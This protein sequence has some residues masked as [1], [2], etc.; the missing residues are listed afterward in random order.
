MNSSTKSKN[1]KPT[2]NKQRKVLAA[3][4]RTGQVDV[5]DL[6]ESGSRIQKLDVLVDRMSVAFSKNHQAYVK[7]I[8]ALDGHVTV[9]RVVLNDLRRDL[10]AT[11]TTLKAKGIEVECV[12][13]MSEEGDINWDEY[14]R[15]YNEYLKQQQ[16]S[17]PAD[18]IIIQPGDDPE[19]VFGGDYG[20]GNRSVSESIKDNGSTTSQESA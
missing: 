6:Q 12:T 8:S 18:S 9:L 4:I 1:R 16:T 17:A 15:C 19:E 13:M 10:K 2:S 5:D 7:A 11:Q 14:Y 20:G 3:K